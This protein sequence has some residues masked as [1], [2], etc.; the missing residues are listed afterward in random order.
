MEQAVVIETVAQQFT[1]GSRGSPSIYNA[2]NEDILDH[3]AE[4]AWAGTWGKFTGFDTY[5]AGIIGIIMCLRII[6]LVADTILHGYA[7]HTVYGWSLNLVAVLWDSFT[8]LL[9]HLNQ[10]KQERENIKENRDVEEGKLDLSTPSAPGYTWP[11]TTPPPPEK[12]RNYHPF[13]L[14]QPMYQIQDTQRDCS[15]KN[16]NQPW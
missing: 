7:L 14:Y 2:L 5:C 4:S 8:H 3:L 10:K 11:Y 13:Q 1:N 9:L 15:F 16:S 6:K 12:R